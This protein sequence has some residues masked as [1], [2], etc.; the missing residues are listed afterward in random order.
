[1][2]D[3]N[4][5][6]PRF[7]VLSGDNSLPYAEAPSGAAALRLPPEL[8]QQPAFSRVF[9]PGRVTLGLV[10]PFKG[11]PD[12]AI[13]DVSDMGDLAQL[14]DELGFA[15]LWVRDVPFLEP[16]FGDAGQVMDVMVTLG[17]LAARTQR[18]A[19]GTAGLVA[20]LRSPAHMAKAAASVDRLTGGRFL[21]GLSSGDRVVE[22]P[23]FG[24][25]FEQRA[26]LFRGDWQVIRTLLRQT[27]PRFESKHFGT[28]DGSID[29]V[30]KPRGRLPMIAI[31]RARQELSWLAQHSD[32][33]IWHGVNPADTARIVQT[34]AALGDGQTWRPFGY[35]NFI[36]LDENP[37]APM[38]MFS[39]IYLRGG[40]RNM[41]R[42]WQQQGKQGLA[43][44]VVN[45]KPTRRPPEEALRDLAHHALP[46]LEQD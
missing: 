16:A 30:P 45:L 37:D 18:I 7:S 3:D 8:E 46:I 38:Q 29:M 5:N 43:H 40:S 32:A 23:A 4:I 21:L 20:P 14:A 17:L 28:L 10:A 9:Q 6:L 33:W 34:L 26:E 13:P 11:Y 24:V 19:L 44:V 42:F 2:P 15:A 36:E 41:A 35:A 31:G 12:T 25:D 22:Y 1:M 39:N 27:F